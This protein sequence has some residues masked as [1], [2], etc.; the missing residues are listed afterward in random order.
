MFLSIVIYKITYI[1]VYIYFICVYNITD[2]IYLLYMCLCVFVSVCAYVH[3]IRFGGGLE[4][5]W[6]IVTGM[7]FILQL[8]QSFIDNDY[9]S[10]FILFIFPKIPDAW[11]WIQNLF[12]PITCSKV[13]LLPL[14][15]M[16]FILILLDFY[17]RELL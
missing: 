14:L 13:F 4:L 17:T 12:S 2:N 5:N 15:T 9:N 8:W 3:K 7:M 10:Y 11:R 6:P 16:V 1:I